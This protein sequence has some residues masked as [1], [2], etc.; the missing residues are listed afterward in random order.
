MGLLAGG[1]PCELA[2]RSLPLFFIWG[3]RV[4]KEKKRSIKKRILQTSHN[5]TKHRLPFVLL[6]RAED[7]APQKLSFFLLNFLPLSA[8]LDPFSDLM[9]TMELQLVLL[10]ET[11]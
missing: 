10:Y 3:V 4:G 8:V 5:T 1:A 7:L 2:L 11:S 9:S 6:K